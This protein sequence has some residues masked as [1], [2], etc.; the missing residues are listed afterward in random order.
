MSEQHEWLDKLTA[1]LPEEKIG[2]RLADDNPHWEF[3]D[4]EMV[5]LGALSHS[6]LNIPEVQRRILLLLS[7]E[8]KDFR[9]VVHLLRTLQ[10]AGQPQEVILA[11]Q[12][13]C[14]WI[15]TCW[16]TAWPD[17]L[18]MKRRLARQVIQRFASAANSFVGLADHDQRQE[19]L[20]ELA[21]LAQ[22]W[23][24]TEKDLARE[25]DALGVLYRR[26]P[27]G[28]VVE[29]AAP[30]S[31]SPQ[32]AA[33]PA[34]AAQP[35]LE[36]DSSDDKAWRQTQL[37]MADILCERQ[38]D[39]PL[40][41]RLRRNAL[42]HSITSAPLAQADG[43]TSLAAFSADRLA[44]YLAAAANPDRALWQQV[45]QSLVLAPF[46]FEGHRLSAAIAVALGYER[47]AEAIREELR[48]FLQ[49]LPLLQSLSFTD[50]TP[51][52]SDAARA[53]LAE[54][55]E[56][57]E[58]GSAAPLQAQMDI[59]SEAVW[60]CWQ[61][62]G[63]AAALLEIDRLAQQQNPRGRFYCQMLGARLL[64]EA[65]MK[66]LAVQ[67]YQHLYQ[68]A[69]EISLPNWEPDLIRELEAQQSHSEG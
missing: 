60:Q 7:T 10:H 11:L 53:W 61:E 43:R 66:T 27:D 36:I 30:Q 45:E 54:E 23:Q 14:A 22:L 3:I 9:L 8:S 34:V 41:Y 63:L 32:P 50:R 42:W 56:I 24:A 44:E 40:G 1:P 52:L 18:V 69:Q 12:L 13:L 20:G 37:Q 4:G 2:A 26:Q 15:K 46:W 49:R 51:F 58:G 57:T 38:P 62:Q 31:A 25:A 65:G 6:S 19:V 16:E 28:A 21:H 48:L 59:D 68:I 64:E 67:S 35:T 5:R 17:N 55:A 39:N 47:V 29:A 33:A